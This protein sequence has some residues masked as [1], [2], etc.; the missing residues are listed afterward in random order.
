M[1]IAV[2][3]DT[4]VFVSAVFNEKSIPAQLLELWISGLFILVSCQRALDELNDVLRRPHLVSRYHIDDRKRDNLLST[5]QE[6]SVLVAGTS[7][8]GIIPDDPKD[9]MFVSCAAEG[10]AKYIISGDKHL[11]KLRCYQST[12]II[13]PAH[14]LPGLSLTSPP[15]PLSNTWRGG[16]K[17]IL[18]SPLHA[19][20]RGF[21]GGVNA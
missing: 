8:I 13:Q 2:V 6:R 9:D 17:R 20:G 5:L 16:E 1:I 3:V 15:G 18:K 21:R 11:L 12:R 19:M 7:L 14:F 4:N 10:G